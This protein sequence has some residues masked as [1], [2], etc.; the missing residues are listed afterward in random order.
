MDRKKKS[1]L[2]RARLNWESLNGLNSLRDRF[3]MTLKKEND[4]KIKR[5]RFD[6]IWV[7]VSVS[8]S[9]KSVFRLSSSQLSG[10][11]CLTP[12]ELGY[13]DCRERGSRRPAWRGAPEH[14]ARHHVQQYST[15]RVHRSFDR[16]PPHCCLAAMIRSN[17]WIV[18]F[19]I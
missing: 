18:F 14:Q 6:Q 10:L 4:G 9:W 17:N 2:Q 16:I 7:C 19:T 5:R 12:I 1:D 3:C 11:P 15:T 13:F 8:S